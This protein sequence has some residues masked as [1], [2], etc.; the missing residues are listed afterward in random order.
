MLASLK[1]CFLFFRSLIAGVYPIGNHDTAKPQYFSS[2]ILPKHNY[3]PENV[4]AVPIIIE[5]L[6]DVY[7]KTEYKQ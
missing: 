6:H 3:P 1:L 2:L 7:T 4:F 5:C